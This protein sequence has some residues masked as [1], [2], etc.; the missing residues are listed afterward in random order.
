VRANF[1]KCLVPALRHIALEVRMRV[2]AIHDHGLA[3]PGQ[4]T[5]DDAGN[6]RT[7]QSVDSVHRFS[8]FSEHLV[9]TSLQRLG[10]S[11]PDCWSIVRNSA[12]QPP[13]G[14]CNLGVMRTTGRM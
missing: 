12:G 6:T 3:A 1:P 9:M 13:W 4:P 11:V 2:R 10:L 7:G 14:Q 5:E 8:P